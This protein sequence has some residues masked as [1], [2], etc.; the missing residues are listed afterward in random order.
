MILVSFINLNNATMYK[1]INCNFYNYLKALNTLKQA[2]IVWNNGT[3]NK[4]YRIA[5]LKNNSI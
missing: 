2:C 5:I 4:P 3:N 1:T